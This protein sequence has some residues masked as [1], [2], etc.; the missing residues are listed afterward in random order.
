MPEREHAFTVVREWVA[1]AE[2]DLKNA[3]H[4][5]RLGEDCPTDTACFHAQ[6]SRYPGWPDIPL[7]E[8]R[9][10]VAI[11]RRV[12]GEIRRTLPREVLRRRTR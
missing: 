10:A 7:S 3:T 9:R 5:L 8:A 4:T 2:N 1:K 11:A 6:Q 12:R